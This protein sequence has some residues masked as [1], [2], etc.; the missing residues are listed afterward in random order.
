[1]ERY[2]P[3]TYVRLAEAL[4]TFELASDFGEGNLEHAVSRIRCEVDLVSFRGDLLFPPPDTDLLAAAIR[5]SGGKAVHHDLPGP[6]GH[7]TFLERPQVLEP[8]LR[9][10]LET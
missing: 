5:R 8:L 1:M 9:E 2:H 10:I 4:M 7:D 3:W 6:F